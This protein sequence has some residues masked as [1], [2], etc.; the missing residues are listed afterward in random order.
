VL[1]HIVLF[2]LKTKDPAVIAKAR[3]MLLKLPAQIP[4]IRHFEVG[5]NVTESP[6]AC[7]FSLYSRFDSREDLAIYQ[8]HPQH[9]VVANYLK[10]VCE[11]MP[12][13]DYDS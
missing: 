11:S 13:V 10:S 8:A 3:D 7:D 2:K 1:T 4:Q 12:V 5:L 6:R 9:V